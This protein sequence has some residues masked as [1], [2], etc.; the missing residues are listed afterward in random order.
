ML[1]VGANYTAGIC[2]VLLLCVHWDEAAVYLARGTACYTVDVII[3]GL[4]EQSP[5]C[6]F[7]GLH[8]GAGNLALSKDKLVVPRFTE[9]M[10]SARLHTSHFEKYG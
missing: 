6:V 3:A 7:C 5:T 2:F 10:G 4:L 9:D 8:N 1:T